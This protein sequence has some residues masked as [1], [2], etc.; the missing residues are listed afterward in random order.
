VV[1][2]II[3]LGTNW[4]RLATEHGWRGRA[5][6]L[7]DLRASEAVR[8]QAIVTIYL[9]F[10]SASL[11][12]LGKSGAGSNYMIE[13]MAVLSVLIGILFARVTRWCLMPVTSRPAQI[14]P[15]FLIL[16]PAVLV[17]QVLRLPMVDSPGSTPAE[18]R[19]LAALVA[20]ISA[21]DRPVLSEDMVLLLKA[22]KRVPWEPA[23][24]A[25]LGSTGRW[26][27]RLITDRIS[28]RNFAFIVTAPEIDEAHFTRPVR[29]AIEAAYPRT[30]DQAGFRLHLP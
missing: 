11:I 18:T 25:E 2:A 15:M 10:T 7:Q 28:T 24:F 26:D 29:Q 14:G 12:A 30:E 17:V 21:T 20:R 6:M 19:E 5:S 1:L 23:I 16:V 22:G 27:E 3:G 8:V 13:W 4:Q 9:L